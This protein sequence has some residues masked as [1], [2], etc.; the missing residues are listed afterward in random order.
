MGTLDPKLARGLAR[1]A[2]REVSRNGREARLEDARFAAA[3][4]GGR[5]VGRISVLNGATWNPLARA[6]AARAATDPGILRAEW[7][8]L[9][10]TAG[11]GGAVYHRECLLRG[12]VFYPLPGG[13]GFWSEGAWGVGVSRCEV[14]RGRPEFGMWGAPIL[15]EHHAIERMA[16]RGASLADLACAVESAVAFVRPWLEESHRVAASPSPDAPV[17]RAP[18]VSGRPEPHR[19]AGIDV[20]IPWGRG[21]VL[22]G[23][24]TVA[25]GDIVGSSVVF[26]RDRANECAVAVVRKPAA[27]PVLSVRTFLDAN[28]LD[29]RQSAAVAALAGWRDAGFAEDLRAEPIACLDPGLGAVATERARAA[30][31][32][33]GGPVREASHL[34]TAF[35]ARL[36]EAGGAPCAA[37]IGDAMRVASEALGW[38]EANGGTFA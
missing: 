10:R 37:D 18:A 29:A 34:F 31:A 33:A 27:A 38:P 26:H 17:F 11:D 9:S 19:M 36:R 2:G 25:H 30:L 32:A 3:V 24:V 23:G 35:R 15:F 28:L 1:Q 20:A 21:G 12:S 8:P 14:R 13:R 4:C 7:S 22:L 16:E 5:R 6:L